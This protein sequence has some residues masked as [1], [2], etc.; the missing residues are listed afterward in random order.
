MLSKILKTV[1]EPESDLARI[2]N[3][4]LVLWL[5]LCFYSSRTQFSYKE[6]S[7]HNTL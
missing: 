1:K 6:I 3:Q 2:K 7:S 5:K 4:H